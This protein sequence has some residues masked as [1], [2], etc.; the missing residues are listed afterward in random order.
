MVA[1]FIG[2][3]QKLLAV[4]GEPERNEQLHISLIF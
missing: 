3:Q 4:Q 2:G 1:A